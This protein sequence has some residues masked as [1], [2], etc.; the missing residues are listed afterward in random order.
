MTREKEIEILMMDRCTKSE[1][2]NLLQ[3]GTTVFDGE[4]FKSNFDRYMDDWDADDEERAQYKAM[5]DQK[6]PVPDWGI[7]EDEGKTYYIMYSL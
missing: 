4:D 1:A 2:E 3:N 6:K 7:V 5:I